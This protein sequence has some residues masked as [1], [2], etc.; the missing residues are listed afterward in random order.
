MQVK[1]AKKYLKSELKKKKIKLFYNSL[2]RDYQEN[3]FEK[4]K[5]SDFVFDYIDNY[6]IVVKK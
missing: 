2:F 4:M 5:D 6:T 1:I 3:M